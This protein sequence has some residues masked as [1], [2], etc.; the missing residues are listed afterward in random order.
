MQNDKNI[1]APE[2][3]LR[4]VEILIPSGK[5]PER[6]DVFLARQVAD[7]TR[8]QAESA[9]KSCN[10]TVNG[11]QVKPAHKVRGG[12]TI[13]LT[14][15]A[16]PP[17]ELTPEPIPLKVVYEDEWL[18]V[19][20]KPAGMVVHPAKGNRT[21]TL[22]NAL[23]A[24]YGL[25]TPAA[26][27]DPDRP[28]VVHRL[29][30][31]TSG[32]LVVCKREP[33]MSRLSEQFR[34]HSVER[35]YQAL[36]WWQFPAKRGLIDAPIGRDPRDRQK[37][38]VRRPL[39]DGAES[40]KP[41]RTHWTQLEKFDFLAH[42][43]LKLETGRTHQIRVHLSH[44]GHPVFGDPDYAGRNRQMGKLSS[45]Q[46]IQAARYLEAAQ[47]QML[48]AVILG[49][50]HPITRQQLHFESDLPEDFANVLEMLRR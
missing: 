31:A 32:L 37:Y 30:K 41:A 11:R 42:L 44:I 26:D 10:V 2:K 50:I 16:Q 17:L 20:D 4:E 7:M 27:N 36:V 38:T 21:G 12:E 35:E 15:L 6:L 39:A 34:E 22:V 33:A 3:V 18:V 1:D 24:H 28:G 47:R 40:G 14:F 25:L 13:R 49:F 9:I 23:L 46:R 43:A 29:D 19:I 8:S 45:A 5:A 48:H